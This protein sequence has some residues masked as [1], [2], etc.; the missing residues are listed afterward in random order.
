MPDPA[1]R[2]CTCR[3]IDLEWATR[4]IRIVRLRVVSGGLFRFRAGQYASVSFDAFPPRDYSMANRPDEDSLEFHIRH[5][6][7]QGVSAFVA[8]GLQSDDTVTV[9][10]PFGDAWLR[11]DHRGPILAVAGGSGLAPIK[12]IVETTLMRGIAQ[13]IH[14][15]FGGRVEADVYLETHFGKLAEMHPN[16]RFIPVLSDPGTSTDRRSGTVGVVIET[17][18]PDLAGFKAYLAGPPAMVE[19]V[20]EMLLKLGLPQKDIHAD[21]FYTEADKVRQTTAHDR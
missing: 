11:E 8:H 20:V 14:L 9:E 7:A 3:V 16:L 15:Y 13:D 10:G 1:V 6:G 18:F 19:A 5:M 4:D 12:S 21:P 2:R 17:E